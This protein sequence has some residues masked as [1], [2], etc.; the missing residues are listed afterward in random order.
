MGREFLSPIQWLEKKIRPAPFVWL[1][2]T[3]AIIYA[4]AHGVWLP[5]IK[6]KSLGEAKI[7]QDVAPSRQDMIVERYQRALRFRG[8]GDYEIRLQLGLFATSQTQVT[9]GLIEY[10][11]YEL[12]QENRNR[13][14]NIL[15]MILLAKLYTIKGSAQNDA[16]L[17]DQA[18]R[19]FQEA[20][21]ISPTHPLI[22]QHFALYWLTR[23]DMKKL[24]EQLYV[25][26]DLNNDYF[27]TKEIQWQLGRSFS[28]EESHENAYAAFSGVFDRGDWFIE[29][30]QFPTV[31][32]AF[33]KLDKRQEL[34]ERY[35]AVYKA[36]KDP[37]QAAFYMMR[38][39]TYLEDP[40]RAEA[41]RKE[42]YEKGKNHPNE[43]WRE[44]L[45]DLH[46]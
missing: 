30:A 18:E 23:M 22:Y 13:D 44:R 27:L 25:I 11:I 21:A 43:T 7:V 41:F 20:I 26:R 4:F 46:P 2:G 34:I 35:E 37:A 38:L 19:L 9:R 1:I 24:Q 36:F 31:I 40:A 3:L 45:R 29:E 28:M 14:N 10:A 42:A 15:I 6:N 17:L 32:A 8:L 16:L 33:D 39:H 12:E 5:Y